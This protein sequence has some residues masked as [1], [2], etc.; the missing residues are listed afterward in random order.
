MYITAQIQ[1]PSI[2]DFEAVVRNGILNKD[3]ADS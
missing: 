3:G 2:C 1:G